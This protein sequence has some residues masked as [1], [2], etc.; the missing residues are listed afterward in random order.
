MELKKNW[1][2][3][4]NIARGDRFQLLG[5]C[6]GQTY[7][8][9]GYLSQFFSIFSQFSTFLWFQAFCFPDFSEF[10]AMLATTRIKRSIKEFEMCQLSSYQLRT[11]LGAS[12]NPKKT[13]IVKIFRM[14]VKVSNFVVF[15]RI[16]GKNVFTVTLHTIFGSRSTYYCSL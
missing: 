4:G 1:N 12:R 7:S 2:S 5:F 11:T 13:K 8:I 3:N 9:M 14:L 10:L 16:W 15:S 6:L